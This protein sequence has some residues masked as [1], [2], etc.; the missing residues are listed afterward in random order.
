VLVCHGSGGMAGHYGFGART[1]GSVVIFGGCFVVTGLLFSGSM[2][3][4]M[5]RTRNIPMLMFR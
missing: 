2:T 3:T 5:V 4:N 1:G